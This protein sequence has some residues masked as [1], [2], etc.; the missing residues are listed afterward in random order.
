MTHCSGKPDRACPLVSVVIPTKNAV[1]TLQRC[2]AS[3]AEQTYPALETIVVDN[4][5]TDG[6]LEVA[7]KH[8]ARV[9]QRGPE[10][11]A[12]RNHG[13]ELAQGEFVLVLDADM[14][15][16]PTAVAASMQALGPG[17]DAAVL[18]L[19]ATGVGFW[20]RCKWLERR[21]YDDVALVEAARLFRTDILRALQGYDEA[22]Y[23][24]ED[25]DLHNRCLTA[26]YKV[27]RVARAQAVLRHDEGNLKLRDLLQKRC[28]YGRQMALYAARHPESARRQF[29]ALSRLKVF[30]GQWRLLLRHPLLTV[31]LFTMKVLEGVSANVAARLHERP[32]K[33]VSEKSR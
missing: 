18:A 22:L 16:S 29:G 26:G 33:T 19:E 14:T 11:S 15:L 6:S 25:W 21:C 31:G 12:Q 9:A 10:R 32:H 28:Y 8:G 24:F 2:L 27:A 3:V 13:I 5:S 23:A 7:V 1:G 17:Y 4:F 20:A 30:A